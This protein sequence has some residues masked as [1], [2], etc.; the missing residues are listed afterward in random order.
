MKLSKITLLAFVTMGLFTACGTDDPLPNTEPT[1][2]DNELLVALRAAA[3]TGS[4]SHFVLPASDDF[5]SIPQDAQNPLSREKVALGKL[6]FHETGLALNPK[7]AISMEGFSCASCHFA[8]AGFQANRVQGI[9]DGGLGFGLNGEGRVRGVMYD[10][11]EVD[12]Q[13]LRSPSAMNLA[14]QTNLLWSGQFGGTNLNIGTE[15]Q[16]TENT[17][18]AVNELGFEG[19]VTQAIAGLG[20][21]RQKPGEEFFEKYP[22]YKPLY[23]AAFPDIDPAERYDVTTTGMAIGAYERTLLANQ[24]PFQQWLAGDM[25]ALNEQEKEGAVLFFTKGQCATCHNGPSLANMEFHALGMKD[26]IDCPEEIF[27]V[28]EGSTQ[29]GRGAFTQRPE[30]NYKFKVPQ[31]YNLTDSPFYGHGSSFRTV[32]EVIAYKNVARAENDRIDMGQLSEHFVP[33]NLTS[34][35]VSAI[36]AF[37]EVGLRDPNLA[38]YEPSSLPSGNCFPNND[39]LSKQ[40]LGCE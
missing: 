36:A 13:P 2:L 10:R 3:P 7:H 38:R 24:A 6:L 34:G 33:L 1:D 11:S 27:Q 37:I 12:V 4:E 39:P 15:D 32:E 23:D 18:K 19:L 26:L 9:A 8:G 29:R 14:Y 5:S 25:S 31:L 40:E 35:E 22:D 30:D 28:A 21:H 16:W 17:P 20:V